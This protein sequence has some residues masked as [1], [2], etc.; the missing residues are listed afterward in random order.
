MTVTI[1]DTKLANVGSVASILKSIGTDVEIIDT[2][3]QIKN[4]GHL[5]LP[6]VGGFGKLMK[7][8][9]DAGVD[10]E[11]SEHIRK[12]RPYLGICL[13]MQILCTKSDEAVDFGL[14]IYKGI[15]ADLSKTTK[16]PVPHIGWNTVKANDNSRLL[17]GLKENKFYFMH[18]FAVI[19]NDKNF[20]NSKTAYGIEFNSVLESENI[21]GV[22][23]HPERSHVYGKKLFENFV[24]LT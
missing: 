5:I 23:F 4:C 1:F 14:R 21:F 10:Q 16:K 18:S 6:G 20:H 12:E 22:Q 7:R 24:S 13:G 8:I 2:A 17:S 9:T 15:C 3:Q 19:E 11:L